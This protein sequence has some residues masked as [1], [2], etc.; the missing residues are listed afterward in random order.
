MW[1][2]WRSHVGPVA[3]LVYQ[4]RLLQQVLLDIGSLNDTLGGEVDVDVLP[5]AT[6]VVIPLCLGVAKSWREG[7]EKCKLKDTYLDGHI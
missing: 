4:P 6:G 5:K 3:Y 2:H 1:A 7:K